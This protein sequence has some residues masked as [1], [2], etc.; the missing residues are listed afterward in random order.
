MRV[1][2][3]VDRDGLDL[4]EVVLLVQASSTFRC[5][6]KLA[7]TVFQLWKVFFPLSE[8]EVGAKEVGHS[9]V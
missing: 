8:G 1:V 2:V 7:A 5:L 9:L 4:A 6:L 3:L